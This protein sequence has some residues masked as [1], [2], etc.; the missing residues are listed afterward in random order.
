MDGSRVVTALPNMALAAL[1]NTSYVR[2]RYLSKSGDVCS[3]ADD[4]HFGPAVGAQCRNG[5][6][7]TLLFEQT[8]LSILPSVILLVLTVPRF[9]ALLR[10]SVKTWPDSM[11]SAK[12]VT[13]MAYA[14]IQLALIVLWSKATLIQTRASVP[15][16]AVS[17]IVSLAI[18][19]LSHVEHNRSIRPST[20]L[21]VYLLFSLLFDVIQARTL[22]LMKESSSI[23]GI[24]TASIGLKLA[25]LILETQ[26]KRPILRDPYR[27]LSP[28]ATSGIFSRS[29]FWWLNGLFIEGFRS[30]L[31]FESLFDIDAELDSRPL[32][33]RMQEAWD[34]RCEQVSL[35]YE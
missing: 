20:L 24:F 27:R 35:A 11:G 30:I 26:E 21:N 7:F 34:Q 18:I 10:A 29:F 3:P 8:I 1:S 9:S 4:R 5:F 23:S 12:M 13:A 25:L 15:S 28:E 22:Y 33:D 32:R 2:S 14:G 16:A 19:A 6:D 17:F 31:T